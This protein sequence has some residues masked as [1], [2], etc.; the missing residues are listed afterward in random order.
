MSG[1]QEDMRSRILGKLEPE[2]QAW[3]IDR[4]D[5]QRVVQQR[6]LNAR[7]ALLREVGETHFGKF[8]PWPRAEMLRQALDRYLA[9]GWQHEKHLPGLP[10][11]ADPLRAALHR[12]AR[13]N[14]GEGI[15]QAHLYDILLGR[16]N[17]LK[18]GR[19][20]KKS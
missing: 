13:A 10:E 4:L 6:H 18:T 3:L 7:D 14:G 17:R 19:I 9:S 11:N 2:E 12:I 8:R 5:P 1:I 20:P 16:R 15:S